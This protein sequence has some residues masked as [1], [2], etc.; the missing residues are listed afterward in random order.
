MLR[1]QWSNVPG[2][3]PAHYAEP[4]SRPQEQVPF[5]KVTG[6]VTG[7]RQI[8]ALEMMCAREGMRPHQIVA[9]ILLEAILAELADPAF[10][11]AVKAMMAA[12]A[13]RQPRHLTVVEGGN[14]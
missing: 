10:A 11:K 2:P 8:C 13:R 3:R 4:G 7:E 5:A 6:R 1:R 14:R 12:R 9:E